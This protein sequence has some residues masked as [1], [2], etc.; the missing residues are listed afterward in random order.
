MY[1]TGLHG[2][3]TSGCPGDSGAPTECTA[4]TNDPASSIACSAG[5][6]ILVMIRIEVATY[7]ESVISTPS[8]EM[9]LPSGPIQNGITYMVRPRMHPSKIS[10]NVWRISS[11]AIQLLVGPASCSRSEQMNVRSSTRAT[12]PGSDTHQ[13]LFGRSSGLSL[14]KV[15]LSTSRLVSRSHSS[16]EPSHHTTASGLVRLAISR[17]Q[18]ASSGRLVFSWLS[19]KS[20]LNMV[21]SPAWDPASGLSASP[22]VAHGRLGRRGRT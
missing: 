2:H 10:A 11:G 18:A 14:V 1:L 22:Y 20:A 15:P 8:W 21:V 7:G 3:G 17:T 12:S 5:V 16:W 6:P 19:G 13:K 4:L 9:A